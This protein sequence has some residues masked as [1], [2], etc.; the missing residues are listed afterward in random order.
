M[1]GISGI[2]SKNRISSIDAVLASDMISLQKQR[3]P[4]SSDLY[5]DK[6]VILG[7][8][9]LKIVDLSDNANQPMQTERYVMVFNGE[10]YNHIELRKKLT[11]KG[12][13]FKTLSDTEVLLNHFD[14]YGLNE[15]LRDITGMFSIALYDKINKKIFL[16]RDRIGEKP[17][18]YHLDNKNKKL[19]FSSNLKSIF[20]PLSLRS[21]KNWK[22]DYNSLNHYFLTS[23]FWE[24]ESIISGI[25]KLES[26]SYLSLDADSF[27]LERTLYW[28]PAFVQTSTDEVINIA[29]ENIVNSSISDVSSATLF[30]GGI[31]SA[32]VALQI[33][34]VK[35]IHLE[36]PEQNIAEKIA[37]LL[38]IDLEIVQPS[39][40]LT[41]DSYIDMLNNYVEFSGEPS[42]SSSIPMLAMEHASKI[43][44]VV[45]TGNGGDELFYGYK[46]TPSLGSGVTRSTLEH[47]ENNQIHHMFRNPNY[48][49]VIG[50]DSLSLEDLKNIAYDCSGIDIDNDEVKYRWAEINFYV[51]NVLNPTLDLSSMYHSTEVRAPFLNHNLVQMALSLRSEHH[52]IRKNPIDKKNFYNKVVLKKE[53]LK[54]LDQ[55]LVEKQKYGFSF[56]TKYN[57]TRLKMLD[58]CMESFLKRG[59]LNISESFNPKN[60]DRVYLKNSIASVELWFRQYV[61]T[62]IVNL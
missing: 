28:K 38:G 21:K 56:D 11:S 4:D 18:Y 6:N 57:H 17:L 1:C 13:V 31:D 36:S 7:H 20:Y 27:S 39:L 3:G 19:F 61:D 29:K 48:F 44:K 53:L 23:G 43:A 8:N 33:P 55:T 50:A 10:I 52:T 62:G 40:S 35:A 5:S 15:T 12:C 32:F 16:I 9:R 59:V 30:S 45:F 49:N 24:G 60:R 58:E 26:A 25:K 14:R 34:N 37:E 54:K 46:R 2:F 51:K 22:I 41:K 47:L 42:S